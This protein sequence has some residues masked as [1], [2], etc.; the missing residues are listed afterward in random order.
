MEERISPEVCAECRIP[1]EP[2]GFDLQST[3][4]PGDWKIRIGVA[5]PKCERS[6]GVLLRGPRAQA[7]KLLLK[8][9]RARRGDVV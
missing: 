7:H 4:T 2:T 9:I 8:A 6:W 3:T 1:G 5:C